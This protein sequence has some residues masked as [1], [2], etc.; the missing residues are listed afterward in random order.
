MPQDPIVDLRNTLEELTLGEE[1]TWQD[2]LRAVEEERDALLKRAESS[3]AEI[4]QLKQAL[5]A[6]LEHVDLL[7]S[8]RPS[9][10][11]VD[12]NYQYARDVAAADRVRVSS[13]LSEISASIRHKE[14]EVLRELQGAA[15]ASGQTQAAAAS[16]STPDSPFPITPAEDIRAEINL[17]ASLGAS[18]S[19][20]DPD[21]YASTI[22]PLLDAV[23]R[24]RSERDGLR[25]S[26]DF[27]RNEYRFTVADLEERLAGM[28]KRVD[29]AGEEASMEEVERLT[30]ELDDAKTRVVDAEAL[31]QELAAQKEQLA[32]AEAT[33]AKL[34][35]TI[36]GSFVCVQHLDSSA[37]TAQADA[38][39]L[40]AALSHAVAEAMDLSDQLFQSQSTLTA[41]QDMI[42]ELSNQ[43]NEIASQRDA[44]QS[45][46]EALQTKIANSHPASGK[47]MTDHLTM[48]L[49]VQ[50]LRFALTRSGQATRVAQAT[51]DDLR[52]DMAVNS[53]GNTDQAILVLRAQRDKME[54]QVAKRTRLAQELRNELARVDTN[55]KLAESR[56]DEMNA[57][58]DQYEAVQQQLQAKVSAL[59]AERA[60]RLSALQAVEAEKVELQSAVEALQRQE[61]EHAGRIGV[62]LQEKEA[63]EHAQGSLQAH[64]KSLESTIA[65][66]QAS[67]AAIR[68]EHQQVTERIQVAE[69]TTAEGTSG[70]ELVPTIAAFFAAVHQ[71][72]T[73]QST[74]GT[75]NVEV[76]TLR[77]LLD[78]KSNELQASTASQE[79]AVIEGTAVQEQL[80]SLQIQ[81][82]QSSSALT[83]AE[84]KIAKLSDELSTART[85]VEIMLERLSKV[86]SSNNTRTEEVYTKLEQLEKSSE[87]LQARLTTA[88]EELKVAVQAREQIEHERDRIQSDVR[89]L[90]HALA[91]AQQ[92][93]T[94]GNAREALVGTLNLELSSEREAAV[95]QRQEFTDTITAL[96]ITISSLETKNSELEV[97]REKAAEFDGLNQQ[98]KMNIQAHAEE[99][100]GLKE[101]LS[102]TTERMMAEMTRAEQLERQLVNEAQ[103][104]NELQDKLEAQLKDLDSDLSAERVTNAQLAADLAAAKEVAAKHERASVSLQF[105]AASS[106]SDLKRA[107]AARAK[108]HEQL[109]ESTREMSRL[110][111]EVVLLQDGLAHAQ[112]IAAQAEEKLADAMAQPDGPASSRLAELSAR[113]EELENQLR[114]K[115]A[116]AEEADDKMIE[117]LKEKKKLQSKVDALNKRVTT[118]QTK[119]QAT[120]EAGP[121]DH[122]PSKA[123]TTKAPIARTVSTTSEPSTSRTPG[124]SSAA[125]PSTS[126]ARSFN[127]TTSVPV[128]IFGNTNDAAPP[129]PALSAAHPVPIPAQISPI[130]PLRIP[131]KDA[132]GAAPEPI[133]GQKRRMPSEFSQPMSDK[134]YVS[135]PTP[136]SPATTLRK[137]VKGRTGFTPVRSPLKR[138]VSDIT[139]LASSP[140]PLATKPGMFSRTIS[141]MD[142]YKAPSLSNGRVM[143]S[144]SEGLFNQLSN[145]LKQH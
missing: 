21:K 4:P 93:A 11:E 90:E 92:E 126:G 86:Q 44:L 136:K 117:I 48:A 57:E 108:L 65:E 109:D 46:V 102:V 54:L 81:H 139:N 140:A 42:D 29:E 69:S 32:L 75:L 114:K 116:E 145:V 110:Q 125:L 130:R 62:L 24:L 104:A 123:A 120:K 45:E 106:Q 70:D 124:K 91:V 35:I 59:E 60:E 76:A 2:G 83:A 33:I 142:G 8:E 95:A 80:E 127:R 74:V 100:K 40:R 72:R 121:A 122:P 82:T 97:F 1:E 87:D 77:A 49:E 17:R 5:A 61:E 131:F 94:A 67:E 9:S 28:A 55:L 137:I 129:Q 43:L 144:A 134:E 132:N 20:I 39:A 135:V 19:W 25:R 84:G 79:A 7:R 141:A 113:I 14:A 78:Q 105:G 38:S 112:E 103:A 73:L 64:V 37:T 143:S 53:S 23:D 101:E 63:A 119:L 27:A 13:Q 15:S 96:E 16:P 47:V 31:E 3:E 41:K 51:I 118:L 26:L 66:L 71:Q 98:L 138:P 85:E 68:A 50:Q 36:A 115:S 99:S 107:E 10:A 111:A 34:Q 52:Q 89:D 58:A 88:A 133:I 128:N 18:S 22:A 30:N 56:I 6:A 12:E